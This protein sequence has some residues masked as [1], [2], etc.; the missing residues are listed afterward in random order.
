M[1][2]VYSKD[3]DIFDINTAY[4]DNIKEA[5]WYREQQ[6][7]SLA[8]SIGYDRVAFAIKDYKEGDMEADR[9]AFMEDA[10][11]LFEDDC[12]TDYC[13]KLWESEL[14]R[15]LESIEE[16]E[17]DM[18]NEELNEIIIIEETKEYCIKNN[19]D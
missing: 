12:S 4:F 3:K 18:I 16:S 7:N 9:E 15:T 11:E 17:Y 10:N 19:G 2:K 8:E 5:K 1:Y 6:I 14:Y 13:E